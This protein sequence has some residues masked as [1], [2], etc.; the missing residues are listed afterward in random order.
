M[1]TV[2]LESLIGMISDQI[3]EILSMQNKVQNKHS[4]VITTFSLT[5]F[6]L[7]YIDNCTAK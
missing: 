3:E 1:L 5:L 6:N 2:T 7:L 4:E